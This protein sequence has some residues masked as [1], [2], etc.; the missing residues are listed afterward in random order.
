[1]L[2]VRLEKAD[3]ANWRL[4]PLWSL[5]EGIQLLAG[6]EPQHHV[7][8]KLGYGVPGELAKEL[9]VRLDI[10]ERSIKAGLLKPDMNRHLAYWAQGFF[11]HNF[12]K[13]AQGK[14]WEVPQVLLTLMDEPD[15][16]PQEL[17]SID[18][19]MGARE[20]RTMLV[21]LEALAKMAEIDTGEPYAA[22]AAIKA[23]S[24]LLGVS[25]SEQTIAD[26]LKQIP[27]A[28]ESRKP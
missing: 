12:L 28:L 27:E 10:G 16:E 19:G 26:K 5:E 8:G 23:Q 3:F 13:W 22:A 18:R 25:I 24:D 6:I 1:M 4:R 21:I 11:P 9:K 17:P 7:S 15:P 14:G 20:R 2:P